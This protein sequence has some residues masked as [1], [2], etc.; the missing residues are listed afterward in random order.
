MKQSRLARRNHYVP[1]WYQNGFILGSRR[2]L[3][4]V[5]LHPQEIK[6]R[7]G[8]KTV[9]KELELRSP[10]RCFR[11]KDLYTTRFGRQWNDEVE[12]FLFG[13][14][15]TSGAA[16][17]RAFAE[18]D[19][20]KMHEHFQQ[21]FEYLNAQKLRTPKGLDWIRSRYPDLT[22]VELM[23]EMQHLRQMH[24]TMWVECVREIVSAEDSDVKFIVTDHP[25]AAYNPACAPAT[26]ACRYPDD[27]SIGMKGT[28]TVFALDADHCLILTNLEYARDPTGVDLE[29]PRENA[30]YSARTLTRTDAMIRTRRLSAEDVTTIN[31]L[32]KSR[33]RRYVAGYEE[34]WLLPEK[35]ASDA[36]KDIAQVLL[37]P[38][39][40]LWNFGGETYI[41]YEDGSTEYQDEFGR[42]DPSHKFLKKKRVPGNLSPND[43]CGCGSGRR[44][45][46]CCRGRA[47]EDRPPWDVYSIRR[48]NLMFCNAVSGILGLNKGKTWEDVRRELSDGQ[49]KNIHEVVE[50]LWPKDTDLADLLPRPDSRVFRAVYMGLSDPRTISV[51]VISALAY[52]DE[53]FVV[54]PFPNPAY[55]A[56]EHSPTK[57]P[58]RHKS[59]L[60]KN[61]FVLQ[62]LEPFINAG[63]VHLVPDP[64]E[65][66]A[67]FRR[68]LMAAIEARTASWEM[69]KEEMKRGEALAQDEFWRLML[70]RPEDQL[71]REMQAANPGIGAELRE[72]T[73]TAAKQ[74]LANDPLALLQP[75]SGGEGGAE[76]Q[77]LRGM[78][79]ELALFVAHLTGAAIY[80]DE[81]GSWRQLHEHTGAAT[82]SGRRSRW[83]P[84]SE[85]LTSLTLAFE[86]DPQINGEIRSSGKLGR[87]RRIFRQI[88][89]AMPM[90]GDGVDVKATATRLAAALESASERAG[91]EWDACDAESGPPARFRGRFVCSAPEKGFRLNSVYRHL[92][93][94]GRTNYLSSVPIAFF[95][96]H[97]GAEEES[98]ALERN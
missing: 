44:Y 97:G 25:V 35:T 58:A 45:R 47:I 1:V 89:S 68:S 98:S 49:V 15:D 34:S 95:L 62:L 72:H 12:K 51:S 8:R 7:G 27:P 96:E 61:V 71:R 80:T 90:Q 5:D 78:S 39:D 66:N 53:I 9:G 93:T 16:A 29:A 4:C 10:R 32:L 94:S 64:L 55:I 6:L 13:A 31:L 52:F 46:K 19:L 77:I 3:Y 42:T 60:L 67:D 22:Q 81:R 20:R 84:L 70:R 87:V 75:I 76:L 17:V 14:I 43:P 69:K 54:N 83:A 28:Q 74:E 88:W 41:G 33:S 11:E 50:M 57:S 38:T 48:R 24:C 59:Q 91:M 79:L 37:P 18:N 23:Q 73:V 30:R 82:E 21:F 85:K 26:P 36:W 86:A 56:Q 40:L 65:Y 92:I 63:I 2:T